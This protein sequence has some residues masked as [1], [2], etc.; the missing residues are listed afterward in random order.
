[1]LVK[2]FG[3][4]LRK[5]RTRLGLTQANFARIGGVEPNAQGHYESG[6]R[7]PKADYLQRVGV[8]GVDLLFLLTKPAPG[9]Y[10]QSV[11][12]KRTLLLIEPDSYID[13]HPDRKSMHD[14]FDPL[15]VSLQASAQAISN[16]AHI[17]NP[18]P[19]KGSDS[20]LQNELENLIAA[21]IKLLDAAFLKAVG[22]LRER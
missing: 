6:W 12:A 4:R 7:N 19:D 5:E 20:A 1:M 22:N 13:G 2:D 10:H 11:V 3:L 9:P 17:L 8:A 14:L 15:R 16:A 21:S 18:A